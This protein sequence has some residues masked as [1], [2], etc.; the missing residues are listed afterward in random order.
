MDQPSL[1]NFARRDWEALADSK[2]I[3]WALV[4][5]AEGPLAAVFAGEELRRQARAL[6]PNWPTR[7]DR[8]GDLETHARVAVQL[9]S[10]A[11]LR[12]R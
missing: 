5:K 6:R 11:T 7:K 12:P 3:H 9:R 1:L 2:A 10:V 8:R 4:K